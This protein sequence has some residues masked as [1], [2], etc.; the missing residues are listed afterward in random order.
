MATAAAMEGLVGSMAAAAVEQ[1]EVGRTAVGKAP[2]LR[3][4]SSR[5]LGGTASTESPGR[6]R[7]RHYRSSNQ[8]RRSRQCKW[9]VARAGVLT[10]A[11]VAAAGSAAAARQAVQGVPLATAAMGAANLV[12]QRVHT[13]Y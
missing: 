7:R 13:R 9:S 11:V 10:A 5:F 1:M 4:L 6:H 3:N 8:P 12:R 2:A